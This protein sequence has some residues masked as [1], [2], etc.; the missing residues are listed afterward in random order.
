[1][2]ANE[3]GRQRIEMTQRL[4]VYSAGDRGIEIEEEAQEPKKILAEAMAEG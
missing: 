1:M 4:K 2:W 3:G